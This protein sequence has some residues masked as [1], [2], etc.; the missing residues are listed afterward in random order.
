MLQD[1]ADA[2]TFLPADSYA[3][4]LTAFGVAVASISGNGLPD[5]VTSTGAHNSIVNGV[6]TAPP[7]VY[8]HD[9]ANP[10]HFLAVQ[11]LL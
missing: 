10:G 5:I 4:P 3:A 8:F 7:G 1:A 9:P 11:D 6:L 2:G